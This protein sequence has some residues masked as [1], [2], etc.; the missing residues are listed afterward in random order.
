MAWSFQAV[1]ATTLSP[2]PR[3]L[4]GVDV[5]RAYLDGTFTPPP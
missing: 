4:D 5:Q 2:G 3:R 1:D